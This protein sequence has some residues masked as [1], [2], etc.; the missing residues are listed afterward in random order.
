MEK[1]KRQETFI[2]ETTGFLVGSAV[3]VHSS[4]SWTTDAAV[5]SPSALWKLYPGADAPSRDV[6]SPTGRLGPDGR[7]ITWRVTICAVPAELTVHTYHALFM[8]QEP[9]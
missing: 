2:L 7:R 1:R 5:S 6:P 9:M 3:G 8:S 4:T